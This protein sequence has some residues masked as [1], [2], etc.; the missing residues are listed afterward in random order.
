MRA[1][2][3]VVC[4]TVSH[5]Q[6]VPFCGNTPYSSNRPTAAVRG[7]ANRFS[8]PN[9]RSGSPRAMGARTNTRRRSS[10][11]VLL[12]PARKAS[13]ITVEYSGNWSDIIRE[14]KLIG[15]AIWTTAV[16]ADVPGSGRACR[17]CWSGDERQRFWVATKARSS[18]IPRLTACRS[19]AAGQQVSTSTS[20]HCRA[21]CRAGSRYRSFRP[22]RRRRA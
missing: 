7:R 4:A 16:A 8:A 2:T 10:G 22:D 12:M 17:F 1:A 21:G 19:L 5:C 20:H 14:T 18:N 11:K 3:P 13:A 15:P 9:L 6:R